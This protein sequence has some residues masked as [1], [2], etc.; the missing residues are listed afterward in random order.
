VLIRLRASLIARGA[1]GVRPSHRNN[2][3]P[4][5]MIKFTIR[6][7]RTEANPFGSE[8]PAALR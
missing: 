3:P 6:A 1:S 8:T 5:A 7:V 4:H 2:L